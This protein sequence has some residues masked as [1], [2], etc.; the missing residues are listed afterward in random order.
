MDTEIVSYLLSIAEI[1]T[2]FIGFGVLV[3][4]LSSD[5]QTRVQIVGIVTGASIVL[6]GCL[7]PLFLFQF[8]LG[9]QTVLRISAG[10]VWV[11]TII[12]L[13]V[14]FTDLTEA[15]AVSRLDRKTAIP[16]WIMEIIIHGLLIISIIG[17]WGQYIEGFYLGAMIALVFQGI[18]LFLTLVT[19]LARETGAKDT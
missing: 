16:I 4:L 17:L 10:F 6:I 1:A 8:N 18:I 19:F 14:T 13:A 7:F 3:S 12:G 5:S 9:T 2:V 15:V 11:S